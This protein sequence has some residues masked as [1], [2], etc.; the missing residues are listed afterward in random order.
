M[1]AL[2]PQFAQ[3]LFANLFDLYSLFCCEVSKVGRIEQMWGD[4]QAFSL[5]HIKVGTRVHD[6]P[7]LV[8]MPLNES[9]ELLDLEV[10]EDLHCNV[11]YKAN[12]EGMNYVVFVPTENTMERR[13]ADQQRSHE[14]AIL[15]KKNAKLI[16]RLQ[17]SKENIEK[18]SALKSRFI[19]GMSHEFR[20][21][22]TSILGYTQ[23]L[24]EVPGLS[25]ESHAHLIAV[26]RS[27]NHLLSL[28]E[29]LLDQAQFESESF[30]LKYKDVYLQGFMEEVSAVI[31]PLAA[32]KALA[33]HAQLSP[34]CQAFA[35]LDVVRLRQV[36]INILGNAVKFTADGEVN[37]ILEQMQD[38]LVFTIR[39]TGPGIPEK[40]YERIFSA[41]GRLDGT[42]NAPGVGL[43][44]NIS[45]R[46]V[47]LM[48]GTIDI[49]SKVGV[50]TSFIVSVP[51]IGADKKFV[52]QQTQQILLP[53]KKNEENVKKR[54]LL[55][56]DNPDI[57][58]LLTILLKRSG[59]DVSVA[60]NGREALH[61][62]SEKEF[63]VVITDLNMPVMGGQE[64]VQ[65]LRA[66]GYQNPVIA[67]TASQKKHEFKYMQGLGFTDILNKPIQLQE[68]LMTLEKHL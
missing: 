40:D 56:E 42:S 2:P 3:H 65:K 53:K 20:T 31:A 11:H 49:D 55:T 6:L 44:L 16:N 46:L 28:V 23:L 38:K 24:S 10:S 43:G 19:A 26:E 52:D 62:M 35:K 33:F 25:Q 47:G 37:F 30:E 9:W 66:K 34:N 32:D 15:E 39:D 63:D 60:E 8:G 12:L 36:M 50:G 67:L 4:A 13:R 54:L 51:Y 41:F 17:K 29:N 58:Q 45:A 68:L 27:S 1:P 61:A 22:L 5:D 18:E 21:P 14:L 64:L 57:S 48:K 7:F 59:F